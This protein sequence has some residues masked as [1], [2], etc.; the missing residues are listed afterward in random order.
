MLAYVEAEGNVLGH[1]RAK[2]GEHHHIPVRNSEE[3]V[4]EGI[5]VEADC[6]E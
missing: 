1:A 5:A 4:A 6:F 3:R 2:L